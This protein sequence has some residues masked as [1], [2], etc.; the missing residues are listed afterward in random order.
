MKRNPDFTEV[1]EKASVVVK[2][3]VYIH[4]WDA[5][6]TFIILI[7]E[8]KK[9]VRITHIKFCVQFTKKLVSNCN[10]LSLNKIQHFP[11]IIMW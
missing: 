2:Y 5:H 7:F 9:L 11:S 3:H 10:C 1:K 8:N 4:S 6:S